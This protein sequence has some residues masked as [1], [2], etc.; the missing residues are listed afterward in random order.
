LSQPARLAQ[1]AGPFIIDTDVGLDDLATLALVA[2]TE[3]PLRQVSTVSGLAPP[4]R[5]HLLAR[6]FMDAVKLSAVPVVAGAEAPPPHVT[7][8]KGDWELSYQ[9]RVAQVLSVMD[10]PPVAEAETTG[11]ASTA[12][13]AIV[14]AAR[15]A[16]GNCTVLALGALTNLAAAS[17]LADFR[18]LV[19]RIVF[20]GD[21]DS[22]RQ[23]YNVALDPG[24]MR[25]L[26]HSGV[27]MV[28]IGSACYVAPS[29]VEALFASRGGTCSGEAARALRVLGSND[30]YSM[31]YDPLA[32]LYHL[33]PDAFLLERAAIP[34]RVTEGQD[35]RFE[36]C[37]ESLK[38]GYVFEASGVS[39]AKYGE[40]LSRAA[41]F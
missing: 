16:G 15:A 34:V 4:G 21:T 23:S 41:A 19:R 3:A 14:D 17:E 5:G 27:E 11:D 37:D 35:W 9:D 2:A 28:L 10:L 24:A 22:R 12:A 8:K 13:V 29:W 25:V 38:D 20:I 39:L 18:S 40:F 1:G 31:C 7:R 32:L 6:R 33:Q 36:R 26:L 30:A